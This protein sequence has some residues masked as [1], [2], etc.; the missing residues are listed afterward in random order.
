MAGLSRIL[1]QAHEFER[2]PAEPVAQETGAQL[3]ALHAVDRHDDVGLG[4][5][6]ATA[7]K[8]ARG[9]FQQKTPFAG[10]H[11]DHA[12][13]RADHEQCDHARYRADD[14]HTRI[15]PFPFDPEC[16]DPALPDLRLP[17]IELDE[18][19]GILQQTAQNGENGE[20]EFE[21]AKGEEP[22]GSHGEQGLGIVA[23]GARDIPVGCS[24]NLACFLTVTLLAD[25]P[26]QFL[27]M[28]FGQV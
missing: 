25:Q 20:R 28:L 26:P 8:A 9:A 21:Q 6:T 7:A 22:L 23:V 11:T 16:A 1:R 5:Q 24:R 27:A 15:K 17:E 14:L 2:V 12:G 19:V 3:D 4:E 13:K 18:A 10:K